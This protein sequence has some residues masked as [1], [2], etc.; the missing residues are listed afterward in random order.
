[1]TK[2]LTGRLAKKSITTGGGKP[3]PKPVGFRKR[4][5]KPTPP[6]RLPKPMFSKLPPKGLPT[7]KRSKYGKSV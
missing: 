3:P 1:M 5:P 7:L 4:L 2:A 6:K